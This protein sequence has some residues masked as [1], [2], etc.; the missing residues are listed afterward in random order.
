MVK[1][2]Q[3]HHNQH[4]HYLHLQLGILV[5]IQTYHL[6]SIL[7][8]MASLQKEIANEVAALEVSAGTP[9]QGALGRATEAE[10]SRS[11]NGPRSASRSGS[12]APRDRK[13]HDG[14]GRN[15]EDGNG[16]HVEKAN[17]CACCAVCC[18]LI[19]FCMSQD[20]DEYLN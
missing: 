15:R 2:H 13:S 3:K 1:V 20:G 6:L 7:Q 19:L 4:L 12:N 11:G 9:E 8:S 16:A 17:R 5:I 18:S 14:P 10:L